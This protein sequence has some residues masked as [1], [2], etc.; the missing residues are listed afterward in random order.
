MPIGARVPAGSGRWASEYSIACRDQCV[1]AVVSG[2]S[3]A[4]DDHPE[5]T[6]QPGLLTRRPWL[7]ALGLIVGA[8]VGG[9][10]GQ[11]VRV[12]RGGHADWAVVLGLVLGATIVG[13]TLTTWLKWADRPP[14]P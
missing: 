4:V 2:D 3:E 14:R 12:L 6:K 8:L 13:V 5:R 7:L 1:V 10:G 9:L 11:G